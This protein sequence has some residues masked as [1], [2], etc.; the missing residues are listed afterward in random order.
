MT[1]SI[2]VALLLAL[3]AISQAGAY[4]PS[5][6][7]YRVVTREEYVA[8]DDGVE[9]AATVGLPSKDGVAPA[10]GPFPVLLT[11]T[12]YGKDLLGGPE[13]FWV[14]RGYVHVVADIRGAGASG[15]NLN[16]NYFSPREQKDGAI[17]VEHFAAK[18]Y[19]NG[20]VGMIGGSY[21]GITQYMTA[22]QQPPSLEAIV[23]IVAL[24]DLYR[25][26]AFHGGILA[27]FFGAQ[28]IGLQQNG[29]GLLSGPLEPNNLDKALAAK[30]GQATSEQIFWDYLKHP[31]DDAFYQERSPGPLA[32]AGKISVPALIYDGWFDGFI[33]GASEMYTKLAS[34][35]GVETRL[36]IDPVPHKG[37]Q[38]LPFNPLGYPASVL[39][40]FNDAALEFFDRHLKLM[41]TPVRA[42]V[43]LFVMGR[44]E[45]LEDTQ[46]PPAGVSFKRFYPGAD[47]SLR[48]TVAAAGTRSYV[49]NPLDGWTTTLSRHGNLAA[50]PFLILDQQLEQAQGLVWDTAPFDA[51]ITIVGPI[52]M[53]LVAA[54]TA[55]DTDW[56]VR[57]SDV[58]PSGAASLLTEGF[59]RASHRALDATRSRPERPWHPHDARV[60]I[61]PG[62][63]TEYEIEVWPTANEFAVGH[64]L[65]V[66]LTS[67]DTP[68][69]APGHLQI[70]RDGAGVDFQPHQPAVQT[71]RFGGAGG[72]SLL[73]P[74]L[75]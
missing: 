34:R 29:T 7:T 26:A 18:P 67:N 25:D 6:A 60:P 1:R 15:G 65:R 51:P 46:W 37:P 30:V 9:I 36:W 55:Q 11:M 71:I 3:A 2:R 66:Q 48:E 22:G 38:G 72:T 19:A 64:R 53:R 42:P 31:Y 43:K 45:Y 40:D 63:M 13:D 62:E 44:D 5:P 47:G 27:Q 49:T 17:L 56:F 16:A 35:P 33:R 52:S 74:T 39:D 70:D 69:H 54:S 59:L 24:E 8:M 14:T 41:E 12:P 32:D 68:N 4:E 57:I 28:Y 10:A 73:I 75:P 21:L 58:D 20:R 61:V 50:S 23:P